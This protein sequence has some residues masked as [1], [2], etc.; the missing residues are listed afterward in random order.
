MTA[1]H[2]LRDAVD[3]LVAER[4]GLAVV[5]QARSPAETERLGHLEAAIGLVARARRLLDADPSP[6]DGGPPAADLAAGCHTGTGADHQMTLRVDH[7]L[8]LIS[9]DVAVRRHRPDGAGERFGHA[10]TFLTSPGQD[11]AA[12]AAVWSIEAHDDLGATAGGTLRVIGGDHRSTAM[13]QFDGDLNG[14]PAGR[15]VTVELAGHSERFRQ[16][17]LDIDRER[18]VALTDPEDPGNRSR[19]LVAAFGAAGLD[20]VTSTGSRPTPAKADG[21]DTAE[22]HTVL[23]DTAGRTGGPDPATGGDTRPTV[24]PKRGA[25][26]LLVVN[27][28]E[29]RRPDTMGAVFA[30]APGGPGP[31]AAVFAGT[32]RATAPDDVDRSLLETT[33]GQIGRAFAAASSPRWPGERFGSDDLARLRHDRCRP[34]RGPRLRFDAYVP[35]EPVGGG[36]TLRLTPPP[37]AAHPMGAV[38]GWGQ[39]VTL[40]VTLHNGLAEPLAVTPGILDQKAGRLTALIGRRAA[41]VG[42]DATIGAP[43]V[44]L[45]QRC[46]GP[47]SVPADP[48]PPGG[49]RGDK[50]NLTFGAH[51]FGVP[52]PGWYDVTAVLVV[53]AMTDGEITGEYAVTAPPLGVTV[54]PPTSPAELD[55]IAD[56]LDP[57]V[58]AWFALGGSPALA[59]VGESLAAVSGRRGDDPAVDPVVAAV[60]R[61]QAFEALRSPVR[62][63]ASTGRFT[64]GTADPER[65]ADLLARLDGAGLRHF[66]PATAEATSAL[67]ERLGPGSRGGGPGGSPDQ[68][69]DPVSPRT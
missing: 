51:V 38:F 14:I 64:G 39:P 58:G 55:T 53:P 67:A 61:T 16:L 49:S 29:A 5:G 45:V 13:V 41:A 22:L 36:V 3:L 27:R 60:V 25:A 9:G 66:D 35:S 4:A 26:R 43:F 7:E 40:S 62:F 37:T 44:P 12:P 19:Q 68:R 59:D 11:L 33:V 23:V 32:V 21:W 17:G 57:R 47:G 63:D 2:H 46:V 56:L 18:G 20:L 8:D 10:V 6:G 48:I 34:G 50:L 69:G 52:E 31:A 1:L 30:A 65:A 15:A 24:D 54:V 28:A 42:A